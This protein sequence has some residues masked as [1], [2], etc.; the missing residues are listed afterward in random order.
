MKRLLSFTTSGRLHRSSGRSSVR[1]P[2][3]PVFSG[4]VSRSTTEQRDRQT[5]QRQRAV[6][7][8][9]RP[10][11]GPAPTGATAV[12]QVAADAHAQCEAPNSFALPR[13]RWAG[14]SGVRAQ[15]P[16]AVAPR[17]ARHR[18][19]DEAMF[20]AARWATARPGRRTHAR[21]ACPAQTL[22]RRGECAQPPPLRNHDPPP[23]G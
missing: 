14:G 22:A 12:L 15:A 2:A 21:A 7:P 1:P 5:H 3:S 20:R 8:E 6:Q 23:S 9:V 11:M 17:V 4:P 13:C 10:R 16:F 19:V 18:G